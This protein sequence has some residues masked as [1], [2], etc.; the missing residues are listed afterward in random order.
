MKVILAVDTFDKEIGFQA[1]VFEHLKHWVANLK[2][3]I[4]PVY[5]CEEE[6]ETEISL[7][8]IFRQFAPLTILRCGPGRKKAA[9]VLLDYAE[10]QGAS[11]LAFASPGKPK[12][13]GKLFGSFAEAIFQRSHKPL[14]FLGESNMTSAKAP[15]KVLFMTDFTDPSFHAFE[16][17]LS[18]LKNQAVEILI[19]RA[20]L[21]P[22][23]NITGQ[24]YNNALNLLPK[25]YWL[26]EEMKA[27]AR[28]ERFVQAAEKWGLSAR[29]V[30]QSQ[31]VSTSEAL[32]KIISNE[33]ITL[34]AAVTYSGEVVPV[35]QS[36]PLWICGPRAVG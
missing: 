15:E 24:I 19:F 6:L 21:L 12:M 2:T 23:L 9:D 7:P 3:D 8:E 10:N 31:V 36:N 14:L 25:A 16:I 33:N 32:K 30:V 27:Q 5:V 26:T 4:L 13:E 11:I 34:L 1:S 35:S 20:L 22:S 28:G 17:L 18:Q 29:V